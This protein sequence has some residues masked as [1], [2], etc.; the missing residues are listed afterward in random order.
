M[1]TPEGLV[2]LITIRTDPHC[3][4]LEGEG[5]PQPVIGI[6]EYLLVNF[7]ELLPHPIEV[8]NGQ[9]EDLRLPEGH[10]RELSLQH[11]LM[12]DPIV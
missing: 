11:I 10:H 2:I 9:T 8:L 3:L 1:H 12:V 4:E 5:P 6:R 7:I